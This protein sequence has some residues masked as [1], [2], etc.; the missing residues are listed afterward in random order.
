MSGKFQGA[1]LGA[2]IGSAVIAALVLIVVGWKFR[3]FGLQIVCGLAIILMVRE[4]LKLSLLP[5]NAPKILVAWYCTVAAALLFGLL[6]TE[7]PLLILSL[8]FMAYLTVAIWLTRS[9]MQN[10][11]LL[12]SLALSLVGLTVCVVFPFLEIE[13]LRLPNGLAWFGLHLAVVFAG[14]VAA[15]FGG[16]AFGKV[17]LMPNISPKK[18]MAGAYAGLVGSLVLGVGYAAIALPGK[19]LWQIALFC[20]ICGFVAQMGDLLLSLMKRVADVKDSGSL[21]PGHGGVL[22]RLDGVIVTCPLIY[23]FAVA[24]ETLL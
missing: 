24:A 14:D 4:F 9:R 2:R 22:D 20:L 13:T 3:E 12:A 10:D 18:T 21:M 1:S 8:S 11:R 23:A 17:K 16:I 6:K 15:Y 19:H 5:L 7:S